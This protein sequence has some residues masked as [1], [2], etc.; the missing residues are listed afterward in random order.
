MYIYRGREKKL[1]KC[2]GQGEGED[3]KQAKSELSDLLS[4]TNVQTLPLALAW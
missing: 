1:D 4:V 3:N 2:Y